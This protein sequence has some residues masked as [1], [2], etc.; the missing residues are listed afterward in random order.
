MDIYNNI[1]NHIDTLINN[2][3]FVVIGIDGKCASGK[4]YFSNIL[5]E[6]Y[7]ANIFRIDDFFL[8]NKVQSDVNFDYNRFLNEIVLNLK[9]NNSFVYEKY[10][11]KTKTFTKEYVTPNKINIIEGV[12]SHYLPINH[13][14]DLKIFFEVDETTQ[15]QRLLSRNKNL[16]EKFITTWIPL[17]NFYIKKYNIKENSNISLNTSNLF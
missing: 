4:T 1:F 12:Y 8:T 14:Y 3:S 6:K 11:C 17:E 7:N 15:K 9:E 5:K 13:I 10:S 2:K 16:Y